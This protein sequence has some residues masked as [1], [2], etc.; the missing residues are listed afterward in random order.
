MEFLAASG[1]TEYFRVTSAG[2]VDRLEIEEKAHGY[3]EGFGYFRTLGM[4]D[5]RSTFKAWLRRFPRPNLQ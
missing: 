2:Q 4:V 3:P 1:G 5:Y